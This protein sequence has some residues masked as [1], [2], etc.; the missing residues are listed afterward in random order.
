MNLR[1]LSLLYEQMQIKEHEHTDFVVMPINTTARI[2]RSSY[3][4]VNSSACQQEYI[5]K[6]SHLFGI[7][8]HAAQ[9]SSRHKKRKNPGETMTDSDGNNTNQKDGVDNIERTM[10]MIGRIHDMTRE[11]EEMFVCI[12]SFIDCKNVE[13]AIENYQNKSKLGKNSFGRHR[14]VMSIQRNCYAIP[15]QLLELSSQD[16]ICK[17]KLSEDR[18]TIVFASFLYQESFVTADKFLSIFMNVT[19][20]KGVEFKPKKNITDKEMPNT[21]PKATP[22]SPT[23]TKTPAKE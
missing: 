20:M 9:D 15:I 17:I 10:S 5:Q 16:S 11:F 14:H 21:P 4:Y 1:D 13:L 19:N 8:S 12:K 3:T 23:A 2:N 7:Q 22:Q 6:L 18:C